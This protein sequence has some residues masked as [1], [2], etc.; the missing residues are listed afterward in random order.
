MTTCS[1]EGCDKATHRRE[2]CKKHYE[3]WRK[4][5]DP[6]LTLRHVAEKGAPRE[7]IEMALNHNDDK[8]CLLWPFHRN[9]EG[10][11]KV[12]PNTVDGS[13]YVSRIICERIYGPAPSPAHETAHNCGKGHLGCINPHH[14]RWDTHAR[15]LADRITHGTL[16][17]GEQH[18]QAVL[19]E[20]EVQEIRLMQGTL[21]ASKVASIFGVSNVTISSI[22]RG[23]A[24]KLK[25]G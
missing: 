7:F 5:G 6:L 23:K 3:R 8:E 17:S 21:S 12:L 18:S 11:A 24:W 25:H 14:L 16:I 2:W 22:W 19:T 20:K 9:G 15:N 4:H 13:Q 1:V 10:Y